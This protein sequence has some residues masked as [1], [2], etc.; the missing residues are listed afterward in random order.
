MFKYLFIIV[1]LTSSSVWG[2]DSGFKPMLDEAKLL[3]KYDQDISIPN[4]IPKTEKELKEMFCPK[5]D[6][7]VSAIYVDGIVYYDKRI[8]YN[9]NIIDRSIIIHEMIHHIQG[10]KYGLT[11][12]CDMWYHKEREAYK[13]QARFLRS[14]RVNTSFVNDVTASLKCPK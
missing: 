12:T 8:D 9:K 2:A 6:C 7:S 10:K 1:L 13:L 4:M 14:Q 11:F 3:M 5:Q